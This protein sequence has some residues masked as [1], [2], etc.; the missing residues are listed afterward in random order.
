M[1]LLLTITKSYCFVC[2]MMALNNLCVESI[3][4]RKGYKT[5]EAK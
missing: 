2:S 1:L 4:T 5:E 3:A